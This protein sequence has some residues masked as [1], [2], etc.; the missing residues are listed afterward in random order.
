MEAKSILIILLVILS[1]DFIYSKVLEFLNIRSMREDLPDEVKDIYD[2]EKYKKSIAYARANNSFGLITST[3]S[4]IVS[5]TLLI[6]GFFGWFDRWLHQYLTAPEFISMAFFALLYIASD[7]INIPFQ[8]YETFVIE[9]KFGFNKT[10]VKT[11]LMDKVKGYLLTGLIGGP[12]LYILL[13]L[14]QVFGPDFWIY[15]WIVIAAFMLFMNMFYTSLILPLFNKLKP[16]EDGDLK[17]SIEDYS[18]KVNFPLDNIYVIDGSKRSAKSN[19]FFTGFG[20]RR[21]IV[22]LDTLIDRHGVNE[23]VAILAHEMGH[24]KKRHVIRMLLWSI[25]QNGLMFYILSLTISHPLLFEAFYVDE[26]SVYAGLLFFGVLY[27]PLDFFLSLFKRFDRDELNKS[28][29][30]E[31]LNILRRIRIIY[32]NFV[33]RTVSP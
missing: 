16:L 12:I 21:R 18:K 1:F 20:K 31:L 7:I 15:F 9:E 10:S 3:F 26:K 33:C 30:L 13:K 24:Y 32:T 25:L 11:Y 4:F 23:L 22:L 29:F 14:M 8:L 6:T 17:Q 19:A 5:F 27:L 2:E 28:S